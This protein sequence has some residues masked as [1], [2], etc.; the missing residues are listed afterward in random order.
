[1]SENKIV[2][3]LPLEGRKFEEKS[4]SEDCSMVTDILLGIES[5]KCDP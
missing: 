3:I 1:M 5:Y 2:K 4:N